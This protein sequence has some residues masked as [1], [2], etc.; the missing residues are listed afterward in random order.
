MDK[1]P[2]IDRVML[3]TLGSMEYMTAAVPFA[4]GFTLYSVIVAC[5]VTP[6]TT[7]CTTIS[8]LSAVIPLMVT[9]P[10]ES[11]LAFDMPVLDAMEYVTPAV[12]LPAPFH[13][14]ALHVGYEP[15]TAPD[16]LQIIPDTSLLRSS[17]YMLCPS[18]PLSP[19]TLIAVS[20]AVGSVA[21]GTTMP[22]RIQTYSPA[23]A[24]KGVSCQPLVGGV[25]ADATFAHWNLRHFP[26]ISDVFG[27]HT[28]SEF[29]PYSI[30]KLESL[31]VPPNTCAN[32]YM[33]FAESDA[34]D[35][36]VIA[37]L[38]VPFP[39][40]PVFPCGRVCQ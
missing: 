20:H 35:G 30:L 23:G 19:V 40:N 5:S 22:L 3:S 8:A 7:A 39:L 4:P 16:E 15:V 12:T 14:V 32:R 2:V 36:M 37:F 29:S 34:M 31:T 6:F 13:T 33:V 28:G 38:N 9:L 24:V 10:L 27:F 18:V 21:G 26:V 17:E 11:M 1:P 25:V